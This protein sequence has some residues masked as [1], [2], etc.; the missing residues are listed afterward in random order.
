MHYVM[1]YEFSADYLE[2]RG[3][4]RSA[5]LKLAWEAAERGELILGGAFADPADRGMLIFQCDSATVPELFAANDP[6][7]VNGLVTRH[8]IR[9]WTTVVGRDAA[10]PVR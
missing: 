3:Q 6:Y 8:L 2:R 5:H 9:P 4:F 10:T 7:V 1:F